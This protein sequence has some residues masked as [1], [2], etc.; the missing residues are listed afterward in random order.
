MMSKSLQ[1][2]G[3]VCLMLLPFS[4]KS[5]LKI[6]LDKVKA[7]YALGEQAQFRISTTVFGKVNYEILFDTRDDRSIAKKGIFTA[8]SGR[9][10]SV[11]TFTM[12]SGGT[13]FIGCFK[14][15]ALLLWSV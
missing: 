7:T 5:Q 10:D 13:V 8:K 6:T 15:A 9:L 14:K 12:T 1:I 11:V 2:L 3:F 4:A